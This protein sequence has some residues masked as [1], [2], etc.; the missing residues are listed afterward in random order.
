M[1]DAQD[2]GAA[3]ETALGLLGV[4]AVA[5]QIQK[6]QAHYRLLLEANERVNL[7]RITDPAQA[8]VRLYADSASVVAW[9]TQR[10][11]K[12]S[13]VLD[14]GTGAGFPALPLAVLAPSWR[15]TA[16][17]GT[18]KK[19]S[20]LDAA[21]KE[22]G[23]DNLSLVH[24]HSSHWEQKDQFDLVT[25]KAVGNLASCLQA[26]AGFLAPGGTIAAFKTADLDNDELQAANT[27]ARALRL[28]VTPKFEY[29]LPNLG[30]AAGRF[31]LYLFHR[32]RRQG[33]GRSK[34]QGHRR[35][36]RHRS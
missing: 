29:A 15:I 13:S 20:F 27:Q 6:M 36:N 22:L 17:D 32:P 24:A 1:P 23:L 30:E 12:I 4:E 34:S 10:N 19:I 31:A 3:L 26:G 25:F 14:V 21:S 33:H 28:A 7:T 8:A 9:A 5:A 35:P 2:F 18:G 16:L 11:K